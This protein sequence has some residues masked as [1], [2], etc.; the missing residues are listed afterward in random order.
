M[1]TDDL[2]TNVDVAD[3]IEQQSTGMFRFAGFGRFS[4]EQLDCCTASNR[5]RGVRVIVESFAYFCC[6]YIHADVLYIV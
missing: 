6:A 5:P 1:L 3:R 4:A 2:V